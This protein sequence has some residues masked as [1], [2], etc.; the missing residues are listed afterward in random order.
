MG[1]FAARGQDAPVA[2][3]VDKVTIAKAK[4]AILKVAQ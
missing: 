1:A 4:V 2:K 3:E